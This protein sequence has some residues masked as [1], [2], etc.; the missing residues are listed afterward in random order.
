MALKEKYRFFGNRSDCKH[1][2]TIT[3]AYS[4]L[5]TDTKILTVAYSFCSPK[6][7]YNKV[8]GKKV[9]KSR[10]DSNPCML[11]S[12]TEDSSYLTIDKLIWENIA[13]SKYHPQY[14]FKF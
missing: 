2:N 4:V 9:A 3:T 6:D 13:N 5:D 14:N 8:F 10:H 7:K 11:F 1:H 12:L